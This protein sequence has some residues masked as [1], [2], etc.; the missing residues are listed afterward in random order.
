MQ[1]D[2]DKWN[3]LKKQIDA[4]DDKD[5]LFFRD[6]EVWW[7]NIG[8]NIGFEVNGK[9]DQFMRPVLILKKYNKYSFLALP[10]TTVKKKSPYNVFLS[11]IDNKKSYANLS[12]LR[13]IDS[14]RLINKAGHIEIGILKEI[15]EKVS[16]INF[17]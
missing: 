6:G 16:Q 12:Q 17:G 2:F 8:L 5:R 14:K 1:K 4:K 7:I 3:S 15:R 13:N 9:D 11:I 10:L